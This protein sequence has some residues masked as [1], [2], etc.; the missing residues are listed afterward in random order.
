MAGFGIVPE[1]GDSGRVPPKTES[2]EASEPASGWA[3]DGAG[4]WATRPSAHARKASQG[5]REGPGRN[6]ARGST[7]G[8]PGGNA[9]RSVS[10]TPGLP[11]RTDW[12]G[13]PNL[14][15]QFVS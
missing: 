3:S 7:G 12:L 9:G 2:P 5:A 14:N 15:L 6:G 8:G 10:E 11:A 4:A 13:S 1:R